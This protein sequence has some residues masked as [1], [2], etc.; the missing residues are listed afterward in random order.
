MHSP[1]SRHVPAASPATSRPLLP[2]R[3]RRFSP[4]FPAIAPAARCGHGGPIMLVGHSGSGAGPVRRGRVS[5]V[6]I[7]G[8]PGG[9]VRQGTRP[10]QL[11]Q[12]STLPG[13]ARIAPMAHLDAAA[14]CFVCRKHWEQ[15]SLLPGGPVAEDD[16][17]VV[18]HLSPEAPGRDGAPVYLGHLLVEPKRHRAGAE[19][20]NESEARTVGLW[21]SRAS[22]ALRE[23]TRAEHVSRAVMGDG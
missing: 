3:P 5:P 21:C 11:P 23:G 8:G 1:L 9:Q 19:R 14:D 20:R 15:G 10:P 16:L 6:L 4:P 7:R 13:H 12:L 22:R 17:V 18:S 2:P